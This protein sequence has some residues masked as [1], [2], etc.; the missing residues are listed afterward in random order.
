MDVKVKK[1]CQRLLELVRFQAIWY[2]TET[3]YISRNDRRIIIE[4]KW[5]E[6]NLSNVEKQSFDYV[7]EWRK[8]LCL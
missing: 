7:A 6:Y 5:R 4:D 1:K 2:H 3:V 8:V